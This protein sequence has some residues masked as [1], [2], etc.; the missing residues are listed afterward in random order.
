MDQWIHRFRTAA[1]VE[2]QDRV[3]IPG[4]PEREMEVERKIKGIPLLNAVT[5]D[6]QYLAERFEIRLESINPQLSNL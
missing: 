2:G 1:T 6:L 4:D 5:E 3:L